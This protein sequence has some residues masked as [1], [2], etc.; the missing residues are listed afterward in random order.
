MSVTDANRERKLLDFKVRIFGCIAYA[1]SLGY[2]LAWFVWTI[3]LK[4]GF[5]ESEITEY[6]AKLM[7]ADIPLVWEE[8]RTLQYVIL[9]PLNLGV[10]AVSGIF[11]IPL[12][13]NNYNCFCTL[14]Y[15]FCLLLSWFSG[16]TLTFFGLVYSN[17]T[18]DFEVILGFTCF[19]VQFIFTI[20]TFTLLRQHSYLEI[21]RKIQRQLTEN[22]AD[23]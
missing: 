6:Y 15:Q 2:L 1:F 3:M 16:L 19:I 20:L 17:L 22:T 14:F 23:L 7:Y 10:T 4:S 21:E 9:L 11:A 5:V 12:I 13:F 8:T 18:N